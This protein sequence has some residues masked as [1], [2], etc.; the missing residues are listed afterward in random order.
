MITP[1]L[2]DNVLNALCSAPLESMVSFKPVD[3]GPDICFDDLNAI[4][5]QFGRLGFISELNARRQIIFFVV[6]IEAHDFWAHGGFIAQ[7]EVLK[8][9]IKKLR[10]ELETLSKELEPKFSERAATITSIAGNIATV[11]GLFRF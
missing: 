2:K 4:L 9:N 7:E 10:L 1:E 11:L 6:H 3:F 8:A 5:C